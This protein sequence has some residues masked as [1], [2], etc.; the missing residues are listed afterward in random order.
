MAIGDTL[1]LAPDLY[2]IELLASATA[3][4]SP[5]SGASAGL[6]VDAIKAIFG[7][8]PDVMSLHVHSTAGSATMTATFKLWGYLGA[9]L[10]W[11]PVGTGTDTGK[12]TINGGA[13][14][15]E[16]STDA[17]MHVEPVGY[18]GHFVRVYLEITAIGGTST[19]VTGRLIG[20]RSYGR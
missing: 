10:G 13:A 17:L 18:L 6:S 5:P 4:N 7:V 9:T 2:S 16:T 15:G 8:V 12:G 14:I 1:E 11:V 19:A 3:A 20:R